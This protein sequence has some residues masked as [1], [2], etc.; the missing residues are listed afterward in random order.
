VSSVRKLIR[1]YITCDVLPNFLFALNNQT[2]ETNV[3]DVSRG[4]GGGS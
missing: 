4:G 3:T 2:N 1:N